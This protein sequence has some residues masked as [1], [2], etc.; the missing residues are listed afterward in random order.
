[1]AT[2]IR[3]SSTSTAWSPRRRHR[4][5]HH[6]Y[7]GR[8]VFESRSILGIAGLG[9]D[10]SDQ[11]RGGIGAESVSLDIPVALQA[12]LQPLQDAIFRHRDDRRATSGNAVADLSQLVVAYALV[13][14]LAP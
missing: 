11:L 6:R 12:T 9:L 13:A 8:P 2:A 7:A 4:C 14:N 1:M 3:S 10:L 5:N